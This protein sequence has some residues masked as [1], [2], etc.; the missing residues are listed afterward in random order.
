[1]CLSDRE[2]ERETV[3]FVVCLKQC[4][5]HSTDVLKLFFATV[6]INKSLLFL[7]PTKMIQK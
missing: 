2:R 3:S 5:L 6:I 1:M 7:I 4:L